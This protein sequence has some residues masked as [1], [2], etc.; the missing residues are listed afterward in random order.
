MKKIL[1]LLIIFLVGCTP[2]E[3]LMNEEKALENNDI[4]KEEIA[5]M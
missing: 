3:D 2:K 1:L 4:S 5:G